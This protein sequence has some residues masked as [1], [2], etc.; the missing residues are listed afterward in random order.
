MG[1]ILLRHILLDDRRCDILTDGRTIVR[2]MPSGECPV[3]SGETEVVECD[4]K[5]ALPGLVNSHIHA[6]MS[7]MRGVGE[8]IL[9]SEWIGRIWEKEEKIDEEYVYWATKVA[10]L[11]MI[12]T[13]TTT[14]YD[15]Y[16]YPAAA[17]K[18]VEESGL[19]A[20]LSYV[21]LDHFDKAKGTVQRCECESLYEESEH[22]CDRL[23]LAVAIHS[24]Y[25]VS[26]EQICWATEF[27]RRRGLKINVHL[28]ETE[29]EVKDCIAE[30]GVTPVK[31]LEDL[32][33]LGP[34]V[35]A[36]HTLWINEEDIRILA[37]RGV[38]CVHNI[39]S[40]LKLS[41]GYRFLYNELR[42]A[43]VNVCLG[44]DGCASSNNLD[45]Q[46]AMKTAAIVQKAWR[47]DPAA[48]PLDELLAMATAN[49]A[50]ALG[51]NCGKIEE[52]ALADIL[53]VDMDNTFFLSDAPFLANFVYSAHSDCIDSVICNGRFVMRHRKVEG[54]KEILEGARRVL[55]KLR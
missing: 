33:V 8:D 22:W 35:T 23:G 45:L 39:N 43:G 18:A 25:S 16:W 48:M 14:F 3:P 21:H 5:A 54:E 42:D 2:I 38:S 44:T 37:D 41:S 32:G 19:R 10:C 7:M 46:E 51:L 6:A 34:D 12:K 49:G 13:G 17:A 28:S 40:N 53:I 27:A 31:Y 36:A 24:I 4:G 30:H 50:K 11:E 52:G 20:V 26:P 55:P 29:K 1:K 15:Q 47:G 9:F